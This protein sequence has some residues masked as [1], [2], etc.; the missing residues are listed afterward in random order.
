VI[1]YKTRDCDCPDITPGMGGGKP[2]RCK[3]HGNPYL[4]ERQLEP[5]ERTPLRRVGLKR[6]AD[7]DAGERPRRNS[8]L[9]PG[10]GFKVADLQR[11]KVKLLTCLGC[12]REV[13]PDARGEWT[14][15]PAHLV[16]RGKGGCDSELCVFPLCRHLYLPLTG[17][18]PIFDGQVAGKSVDLHERLARGGYEQELAHAVG[19]HGLTPIELV[20][21]VTGEPYRSVAGL[22]AELEVARG[23]IV[24]LEA[25]VAA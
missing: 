17:C 8:T 7:I 18:H 11:E 24:E 25:H 10:R 1:T 20:E 5:K 9:K 13:D 4:S 3:A 19:V 12:G 16:P 6:Q 21:R 23:R 22:V 2:D 15:D 14:I